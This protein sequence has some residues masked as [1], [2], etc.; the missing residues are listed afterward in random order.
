MAVMPLAHAGELLSPMWMER[1]SDPHKARR[2]E[3]S[4]CI[5]D[6]VTRDAPR[7]HLTR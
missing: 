6:R 1:M 5:L 3:G 2:C 7:T 4:I